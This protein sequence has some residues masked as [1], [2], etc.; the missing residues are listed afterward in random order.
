MKDLQ[1]ALIILSCC[2]SWQINTYSQNDQINDTTLNLPR[3]WTLQE[4]IDYALD[5]N[6]TIKMNKINA[7]SAEIDTKTAKAAFFP[8]LNASIGQ[9]IVNNPFSENNTIID[10]DKITSSRSKTNYNGS[11]GIDASWT[12]YNG[13]RRI[14]TLKLQQVAQ[15]VADLNVNESENSIQESI[16]QNYIQIL[17][18]SEAVKINESTLEVS[19]AECERGLQLLNSGNLSK[20]DYAQLEAQYSNNKYMLVTA[21][22]T[23]ANYKLQLKQLLEIDGEMDFDICI[24]EISKTDVLTPIPSKEDIYQ[25]ALAY[26]PE[27]QSTKLNIEQSDLNIDIAKSG[28]IPTLSLSAGIGTSHTNG[29]DFTFAE[30]MKTN[31]N[32]SI[33]LTLSIPI[34]NNRQTKSNIQKAKLEKQTSQLQLADKQKNLY[35]TIEGLWLDA[36]NSQQQ[37]EAANEKLKST[38]MSYE[39][40]SEQFNLGMKNTVELLTEKSNYLNAQQEVLQSKYMTIMNL[41][42]LNFYKN[43]SIKI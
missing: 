29:N 38:E 16:L 3:Q 19:K 43:G 1:K 21:K 34:L 4:C 39:L 22:A 33:G 40:V 41:A 32:N 13:S 15:E 31:W 36:V 37:Y 27:I 30:Q 11:Y 26:R 8:S 5:K 10:G 17:Y 25:S 7:Q 23:L 6:I 28:Y 2:I 42:L 14:K 12:I 18:A 24:P 9:R 20:A 35:K